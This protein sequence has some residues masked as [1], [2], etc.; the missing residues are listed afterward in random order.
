MKKILFTCSI[1]VA[2]LASQ[3]QELAIDQN[4]N[5]KVSMDKYAASQL[6]LQT[7]NNTT[8]QNTYKAYDFSEAK[9]ERR[10]ER[11]NLRRER[12]MYYNMN[13]G[14]YYGN[15]NGFNDYYD[16]SNFRNGSYQIY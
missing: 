13:N 16:N 10:A 15:N 11:R 4:P 14:Y 12:Q 9:A 1:L 3:A 2:S 6:S 5:Y 7:T 8:T